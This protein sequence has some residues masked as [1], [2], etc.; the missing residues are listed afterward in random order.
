M[1]RTLKLKK[2][3]KL[4]KIKNKTNKQLTIKQLTIKHLTIKRRKSRGGRFTFGRLFK[5]PKVKVNQYQHIFLEKVGKEIE[6]TDLKNILQKLKQNPEDINR[7]DV[8][9]FTE[10]FDFLDQNKN[11]FKVSKPVLSPDIITNINIFND[12]IDKF[13]KIENIP[14]LYNYISYFCDVLSVQLNQCPNKGKELKEQLIKLLQDKKNNDDKDDEDIYNF[15]YLNFPRD[16]STIKC[17]KDQKTLEFKN[18]D[19][20]PLINNNDF[21]DFLEKQDHNDFLKQYIDISNRLLTEIDINKQKTIENKPK[22]H[23]IFEENDIIET[24]MNGNKEKIKYLK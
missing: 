6:I 13:S 5:S 4:K 8:T 11:Y 14:T 10:F 12:D 2:K 20:H 16:V 3:Y 19:N 7:N 22:N 15:I 23:N 9:K 21:I 1:F 24:H 18:E 17:T